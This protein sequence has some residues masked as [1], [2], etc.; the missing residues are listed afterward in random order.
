METAD[1][2]RIQ[3]FEE[4]LTQ[5]LLRLCTAHDALGG[6]LLSTPDIDQHW[7]KLAPEYMADSVPQIQDYP[8]VS[9]AWAAYIGMAIAWGWD[10]DWERMKRLSYATL[11]GPRGYDDMDEHI[12]KDLLDLPLDG[13]EAKKLAEL[14]RICGEQT[15]AA[16]RHEG[17]EPQ[18]PMAFYV[19][20]AAC[21]TMYR[22]GAAVELKRLGY[23][24][25]EVAL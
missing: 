3:Q 7:Q 8:V 5:T 6:T 20:A 4:R 21:E 19:F 11:Y 9:V 12:V 23:K 16:I 15:V 14:W 10:A 17:I 22:F 13:E 1:K 2:V 25:E 24:F 18:S